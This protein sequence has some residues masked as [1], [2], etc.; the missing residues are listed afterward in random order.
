VNIYLWRRTD[1][2][3]LLLTGLIAVAGC[4]GYVPGR[5][6]YW[7]AQVK[8]MCAKDGGVQI[9]EKLH[10]SKSDITLLDRIDNRIAIPSKRS[11]NPRAPAYSDLYITYLRKEVNP[12]VWR[13]ESVIKRRSD[14][15]VIARWVVYTRVGGDFPSHAHESHFTC[16]E[17]R[18]ITSDLQRLFIIDG[19][20]Q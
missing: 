7:G 16:P 3:L 10:I 14:E 2:V 18:T 9:F 11:A 8:E 13:A 5:Q 19:E 4:A 20:S 17:L 12:Q 6:A 1:L 15:V